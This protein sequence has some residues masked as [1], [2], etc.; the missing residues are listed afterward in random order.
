MRAARVVLLSLLLAGTA[1]A[2]EPSAK[3]GRALFIGARP[4]QAG[5][6]PCGACHAPGGEGL[7]FAASL[8]PDLSTSP[9]T[10]DADTL[11]GLL[12]SNP[13]PT[14]APIYD[15]RALTPAER[16]DVAAYLVQ[17]AKQGP[18]AAAWRFEAC[19]SLVALLFFV[20]LALGSR[21]RKPHPRARLIARAYPSHDGG[22]R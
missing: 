14:M 16:A 10:E 21:R 2:V 5:G 17:A 4:F 1:G 9:A 11:V 15:V 3:Q 22:S 18:P 13:F 8:G 20:A 6:A 19:A 7:A 12:E